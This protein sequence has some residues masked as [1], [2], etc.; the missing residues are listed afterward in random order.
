MPCYDDRDSYDESRIYELENKLYKQEKL[1]FEKTTKINYLD[2]IICA[3]A[4]EL[5]RRKILIEVI[6][7][8][9]KNGKIDIKKFIEEHQKKDIE[10]I[11]S[12]L[13]AF[14]DDEIQLIKTLIKE[15]LI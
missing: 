12:K 1:D 10:R 8:A 5:S 15:D 3:I 4:N 9:E 11:K 2:A 14:S 13:E 6:S 7:S